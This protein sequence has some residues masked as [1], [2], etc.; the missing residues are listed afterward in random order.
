M[1]YGTRLSHGEDIDNYLIQP[2]VILPSGWQFACALPAQGR[3]PNLTFPTV[4]L[5]KLVDSPLLTGRYFATY[6]LTSVSAVRN[7]LNIA[8]DDPADL[9]ISLEQQQSLAHLAHEARAMLGPWPFEHYD[10][11]INISA[12]LRKRPSIGGQEHSESSDDSGGP[13]VF[14]TAAGR[15]TV[16]DTLSHEYAHS[17]NG[18]YRRPVGE[19]THDYQE[20]YDDSLNWVY[21]GLTTYLGH[22]LSARAGFWTLGEFYDLWANTAAEMNYRP[23]RA[24]RS[25]QDT[26]TSL[27]TLMRAGEGWTSWRRSADYYPEGALLWLDVDVMIRRQ[28]ANRKSLDDFLRIFLAKKPG[29]DPSIKAYD[30]A[31]IVADLNDV[32]Q[33][34]WASFLRERLDS[35]GGQ[36]PL[37]GL[38]QSGWRVAYVLTRMRS[39]RHARGLSAWMLPSRSG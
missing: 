34:D 18:K 2:S 29:R 4:T 8:A 7:T 17:W 25:L 16:A 35:H 1:A 27:P 5:Q 26:S 6:Q 21:E 37:G 20:P 36:P 30:F 3:A 15:E 28:T 19:V 23:G 14:S 31:E 32:V 33:L 9:L 22:V 11:L 38:T 24:W 13:G 39:R 12:N 10:F